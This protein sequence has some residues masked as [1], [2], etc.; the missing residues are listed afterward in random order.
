M[1]YREFP[2]SILKKY[3]G[4]E[5]TFNVTIPQN[6]DDIAIDILDKEFHQPYDYQLILANNPHHEF[7]RIVQKQVEDWM[8][9]LQEKGVISGHIQGEYI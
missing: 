6:G 3:K 8:A 9:Y 1:N 4:I 2:Q 5:I 7:A